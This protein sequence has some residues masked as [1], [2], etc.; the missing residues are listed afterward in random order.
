M[1]YGVVKHVWLG[2]PIVT[3]TSPFVISLLHLIQS[4]QSH[5][6]RRGIELEKEEGIVGERVGD[7]GGRGGGR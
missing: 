3:R 6:I 7:A 1:G 5:Y 2:M 4:I